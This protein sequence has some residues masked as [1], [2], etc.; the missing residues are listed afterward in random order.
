[1]L[2]VAIGAIVVLAGLAQVAAPHLFPAVATAIAHPFWRTEFAIEQGALDSRETLLNENQS[3]LRQLD[4]ARVRLETMGAIESENSQLKAL[5]GRGT[6]TSPRNP[7]ILAAVLIKP[8]ASAYDELIIDIGRDHALSTSSLVYAAG[9]VLIGRVVNVLGRTSMIK[10]FS[11]PGESY[12]ILIGQTHAAAIA[13]GR[14]GG[15]YEAQLSR[16]TAVV[17]GDVVLNAG[18]NNRPFGIVSA[19]L[20]DPTQPFKMVLFAPP[21]NLYQLRWVVVRNRE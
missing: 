19:V 3:L 14:G 17:E 15:Q 21:A 10:L 2:V 20:L 9:D 16:D 8:P 6:T 11:S 12:P 7:G 13:V 1:M 5:L 18:L 4:E